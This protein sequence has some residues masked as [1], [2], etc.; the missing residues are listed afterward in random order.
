MKIVRSIVDGAFRLAIARSRR[1]GASVRVQPSLF[2]VHKRREINQID[3]IDR[4]QSQSIQQSNAIQSDPIH[5]WIAPIPARARSKRP[6]VRHRAS[7]LSP[8]ALDRA[9]PPSTSRASRESP[10]VAS[11]SEECARANAV[12]RVAR[13][14][15]RAV[16]RSR[17]FE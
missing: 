14:V 9:N 4:D 3:A 16:A 12:A 11:R 6:A 2:Y 1:W 10:R 15:A 13:D 7:A 5:P 8:R 17:A